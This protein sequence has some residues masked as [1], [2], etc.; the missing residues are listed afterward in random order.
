MVYINNSNELYHYGV[1]GMKW[2]VRKRNVY[3]VNA[4][5]YN[6]RAAK[7]D[8]KARRNNQMASM[9]RAVVKNAPGIIS[10]VNQINANYYQKKADKLTA[11]ADKNRTMADLNSQASK[12]QTEYR[13]SAEYKAKRAKAIK[14]GAAAAGTALAV[15]GAY[16]VSKVLKDKAATKS[17]EAGQAAMKRWMDSAKQSESVGNW[18]EGLVKNRTAIEV[19][20]KADERT[21]R[22]RNSTVEAAKYLYNTR[23]R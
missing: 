5:Y 4:A 20:R 18:A 10:K 8:A 15:Y 21:A 19:A 16:K 2:G 3:D 7:L 12:R 14:V 6:K 13:Q 9:N 17:Y 1:K 11:K 23:K 22:V